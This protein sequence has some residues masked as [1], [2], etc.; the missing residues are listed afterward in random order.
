VFNP[1]AVIYRQLQRS[2]IAQSL[3]R[4]FARA[5][6]VIKIPFTR[7]HDRWKQMT[8]LPNRSGSNFPFGRPIYMQR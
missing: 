8:H 6:E 2:M 7:Y 5:I 3:T 1:T 4:Y